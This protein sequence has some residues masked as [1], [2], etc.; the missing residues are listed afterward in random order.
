MI[1]SVSAE[2]GVRA[3]PVIMGS[4]LPGQQHGHDHDPAAGRRRACDLGW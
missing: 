2:R 1:T 4:L 3:A